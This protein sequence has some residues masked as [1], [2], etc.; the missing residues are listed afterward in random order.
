MIGLSCIPKV[1]SVSIEHS[2]GLEYIKGQHYCKAQTLDDVL[3][4]MIMLLKV[5][6][7]KHLVNLYSVTQ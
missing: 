1:I 3:Q 7:I 4:Y 5:C 2:L 6:F